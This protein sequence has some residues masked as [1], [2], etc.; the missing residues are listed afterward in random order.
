MPRFEI[1]APDE[2]LDVF[3]RRVTGTER[4]G[5][6]EAVLDFNPGLALVGP[7]LPAGHRIMIPDTLPA[8]A[9]TVSTRPKTSLW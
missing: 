7:I 6:T 3:V 1:A 5:N 2:P 4:L 8:A 9:P